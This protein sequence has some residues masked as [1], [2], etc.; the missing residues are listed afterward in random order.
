M[1]L[2][3]RLGMTHCMGL[4]LDVAVDMARVEAHDFFFGGLAQKEMLF[5][6]EGDFGV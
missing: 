4:R 6:R 3:V 2:R 1:Q 5:H